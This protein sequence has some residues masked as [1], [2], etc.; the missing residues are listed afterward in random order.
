MIGGDNMRT[1][2]SLSS[3]R[4]QALAKETLN[5]FTPIAHRLGMFQIKSELEDLCLKYLEPEKYAEIV[6]E[7]NSRTYNREKSLNNL[8]KRIADDLFEKQIPIIKMESRVKS[9]YSIYKKIYV[10]NHPMDEIYDLLAIRIIT[11]TEINCYEILGLIHSKYKPLPKRFKDYIAMPK[12]NMYQSL[13][14]CIFSGDGN[15]FEIQIRTKKMD[16]IAETGV[17][18]HWRYKEG[19]NYN[20]KREQKEI[21]EKLS[22]FRNFISVTDESQKTNA[23]EL[24]DTL[25][26][27]V[28]ESNVYVFTPLGKVIDL[29][30]GATP[31]DFAFKIHSKVGEQAVGALVNNVLVPLSKELKTG[32]VVEIK[33]SQ[34]SAGPTEDWLKIVK[35]NSAQ[36]KIKRFLQLKNESQKDELIKKG[37][38]QI[39]KEFEINGLAKEEIENLLNVQKVLEKFNVNDLNTLY[40]KIATKNIVPYNILEFLHLIKKDDKIKITK[41]KT[42]KSPVLVG[43]DPKIHSFLASCCSPIP[44]DKIVGYITKG[45]G[46][47]VHRDCCPNITKNSER[48]INVSWNETLTNTYFPVNI[49]ITSS[50]SEKLLTSVVNLL[51]ELSI[52]VSK[53]TTKTIKG[54][55]HLFLTINVL[56]LTKLESIFQSIRSITTVIEVKRKL[57]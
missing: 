44:G 19:T 7:L 21:E 11:E 53:V 17:A 52:S 39:E 50:S 8:E 46:I 18:A 51:S 32:D 35:S 56:N 47:S 12:P 30:A 3:E 54:I 29:P 28:F 27:D 37:K 40:F 42:I 2:D 41:S 24:I 6:K 43:N 23:E 20:A 26:H 57:N 31:L 9:I 16:E 34:T 14:T 38:E 48:L 45:K 49:V 22:W 15:I 5:V 36:S 1:L 13:H 10:K 25:R 4:Q 55:F 33:T